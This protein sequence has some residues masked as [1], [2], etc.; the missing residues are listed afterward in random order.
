MGEKS[1]GSPKRR[2]ETSRVKMGSGDQSVIAAS[3][4]VQTTEM[5]SGKSKT[6][7]TPGKIFRAASIYISRGML[8]Y[9]IPCSLVTL[10]TLGTLDTL[11]TLGTLPVQDTDLSKPS[12]VVN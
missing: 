4:A 9:L 7:R 10:S 12:G 2:L 8:S 3:T 11:G 5:R 6:R 1:G